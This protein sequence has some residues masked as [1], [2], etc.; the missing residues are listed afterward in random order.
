MYWQSGKATYFFD[1]DKAYVEVDKGQQ[2][3]ERRE[4]KTGLSDGINIQVAEGLKENEK[5]KKK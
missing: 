5:I 2:Q 4:V 3:F 1:Q